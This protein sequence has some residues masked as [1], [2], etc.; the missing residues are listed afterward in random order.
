MCIP[1]PLALASAIQTP[2]KSVPCGLLGLCA[3]SYAH[4]ALLG[5]EPDWRSIDSAGAAPVLFPL[6]HVALEL[7]APQSAG[8]IAERL[9][10]LLHERG[11]GLQM[12]VFATDDIEAEHQTLRRRGL[13]HARKSAVAWKCRAY[14]RAVHDSAVR[15]TSIHT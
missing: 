13:E 4:A 7:L 10:G 6:E 15:R 3:L 5:R 12:L 9:N 8:P 2:P 1:V 14:R 11:P